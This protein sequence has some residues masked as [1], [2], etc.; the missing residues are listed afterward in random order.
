MR[1]R[2]VRHQESE[3]RRM[4]VKYTRVL[5]A[6][7]A[8][9]CLLFSVA[10]ADPILLA[11]YDY[12]VDGGGASDPPRG[13]PWEVAFIIQLGYYDWE[14]Y[15]VVRAL[16]GDTRWK[17]GD[18]GRVAFNNDNS[19][20]FDDFAHFATNGSEELY[21]IWDLNRGFGGGGSAYVPEATL[22]GRDVDLLGN[23]L[24]EVQLVVHTVEFWAWTPFPGGE[25]YR[26]EAD[27][28]WEFYG[29]PVPEP[30]L[31][32]FPLVCVLLLRS[33]RKGRGRTWANA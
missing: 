25:G 15:P 10:K 32:V 23:Q 22:L 18:A 19:V 2:I 1:Q 27:M 20:A 30:S 17:D 21:R 8:A 7:L 29:H 6:D 3:S 9:T 31:T 5:V 13:G 4:N 12:H 28:T 33:A 14:P 26:Y 16:G 11:S 24:T